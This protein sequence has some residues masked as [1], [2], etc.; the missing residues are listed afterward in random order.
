MPDDETKKNEKTEVEDFSAELYI[1]EDM[2]VS[3]EKLKHVKN[4]ASAQRI[5]DYMKAK[6]PPV[7]DPK[8]IKK[9]MLGVG[10][11]NDVDLPDPEVLTDVIRKNMADLMK[12]MRPIHFMNNRWRKNESRL[13]RV[14]TDDYPEGRVI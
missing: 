14:Y 2:G 1:L 10:T 5:I 7:P 4:R 8:A 13:M 3:Q 9:N 11:E 6:A 12:P